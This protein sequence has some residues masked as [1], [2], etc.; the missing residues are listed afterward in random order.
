MTETA[1]D[2][3][4]RHLFGGYHGYGSPGNRPLAELEAFHAALHQEHQ[5]DYADEHSPTALLVDETTEH[6]V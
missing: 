2:Q 3:I 1:R 6:E 4:R 5:A